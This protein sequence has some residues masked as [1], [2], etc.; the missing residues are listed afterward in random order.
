VFH[1]ALWNQLCTVHQSIVSSESTIVGRG[2]TNL[3]QLCFSRLSLSMPAKLNFFKTPASVK[4]V[5]SR[6]VSTSTGISGCFQ[7]GKAKVVF[8]PTP[9]CEPPLAYFS[10]LGLLLCPRSCMTVHMRLNYSD[11]SIRRRPKFGTLCIQ[12][13]A[14]CTFGVLMRTFRV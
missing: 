5:S 10:P 14:V 8:G 9:S 13:C 2:Q 6:T 4:L 12:Y 3:S 1:T 11:P 7:P